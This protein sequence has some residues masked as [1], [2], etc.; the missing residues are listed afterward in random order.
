MP[1]ICQGSIIYALILYS[2]D[3]SYQNN[4]ILFYM[5]KMQLRHNFPALFIFLYNSFKT[6]STMLNFCHIHKY[7]KGITIKMG[8][9]QGI[10]IHVAE[11]TNS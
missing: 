3:G 2:F 7:K 6:Q 11:P 9:N 4:S 1:C 8:S 5:F 10:S